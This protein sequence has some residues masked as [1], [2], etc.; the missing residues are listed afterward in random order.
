MCVMNAG[1]RFLICDGD[2]NFLKTKVSYATKD[3]AQAEISKAL[4]RARK[5][6][7]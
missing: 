2:W 1:G 5:F 7:A 3:E 4:N 6:I